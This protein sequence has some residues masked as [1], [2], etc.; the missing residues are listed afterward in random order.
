M[1]RGPGNWVVAACFFRVFCFVLFCVTASQVTQLEGEQPKAEQ[2][3][4]LNL[5]GK[6]FWKRRVRTH[7]PKVKQGTSW[8]DILYQ[9][10][11]APSLENQPWGRN[12]SLF[13]V[14][15]YAP[16]QACWLAKLLESPGRGVSQRARCFSSL[17]SPLTREAST[18]LGLKAIACGTVLMSMRKRLPDPRTPLVV[19]RPRCNRKFG[20]A[21][22]PSAFSPASRPALPARTL[23][24][25]RRAIKARASGARFS[26]TWAG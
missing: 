16:A 19:S 25:E 12:G 24:G 22:P 4:L 9:R 14:Y 5:G 2:T 17:T 23:I 11:T 20:F 18:K 3:S 1:C 10:P 13:P 8:G 7:F 15:K 21:R 26:G 6:A